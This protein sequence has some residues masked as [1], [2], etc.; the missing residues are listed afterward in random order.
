MDGVVST[1]RALDLPTVVR[2]AQAAGLPEAKD[3]VILPSGDAGVVVPIDLNVGGRRPRGVG[4]P[5]SL[6]AAQSKGVLRQC[7]AQR[8][9]APLAAALPHPP[10]SHPPHTSQFDLATYSYSTYEYLDVNH[11]N[12]VS[13]A[14][15]VAAADV[16]TVS[17]AT[18][19]GPRVMPAISLA[20]LAQA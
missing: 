19:A 12:C 5:R 14:R 13:A 4:A 9:R 18:D 7:R 11:P 16:G 6:V 1:S 10:C 3:F 15:Y 8:A 17:A 2:A 20:D